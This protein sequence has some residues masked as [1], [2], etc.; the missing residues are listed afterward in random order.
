MSCFTLKF[1]TILKEGR[2]KHP[3]WR[4]HAQLPPPVLPM[5]HCRAVSSDILVT[6]LCRKQTVGLGG[7]RWCICPSRALSPH[8][9]PWDRPVQSGQVARQRMHRAAAIQ[10]PEVPHMPR[11][12]RARHFT[13][14]VMG[15]AHKSQGVLGWQ[16]CPHTHIRGKARTDSAATGNATMQAG[17]TCVASKEPALEDHGSL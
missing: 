11:A 9:F 1:K 8:R 7:G 15:R 16:L 10:P 12:P 3:G 14:G 13:L 6:S 4:D 5:G 2:P 17:A